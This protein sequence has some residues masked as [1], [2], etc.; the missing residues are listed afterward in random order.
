MDWSSLI[1]FAA[2]AAVIEISPGPNFLLMTRSITESGKSGALANVVGFSFSY[3][4]HGALAIY[5]VSAV[6]AAEAALLAVIQ[7]AGAFY[8]LYLGCKSFIPRSV[9]E[10]CMAVISQPIDILLTPASNSLV[11][12]GGLAPVR[13]VFCTPYRLLSSQ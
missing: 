13:G 8:L 3:M 11:L 4:L 2:M 5:G 10:K 6:L 1:A 7:L 9:E 12:D